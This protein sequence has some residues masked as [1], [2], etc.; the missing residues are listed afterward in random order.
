MAL[1]AV[2]AFDDQSLKSEDDDIVQ[3]PWRT[4][5]SLPQP[6][7]HRVA[8]LTYIA[9]GGG[10]GYIRIKGISRVACWIWPHESGS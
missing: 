5:L 1:A 9:H 7:Q 6:F 10:D 4:L 3:P 2:W 8:A